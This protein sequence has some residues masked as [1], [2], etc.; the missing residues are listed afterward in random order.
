M[1]RANGANTNTEIRALFS[2]PL[3]QP[4][5][6]TFNAPFPAAGGGLGCSLASGQRRARGTGRGRAGEGRASRGSCAHPHT[7]LHAHGHGGGPTRPAPP[8]ES[9]RARTPA[10]PGRRVSDRPRQASRAK[11]S[12]AD[13]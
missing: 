2:H 13:K 1:V 12:G 10:N 4:K 5:K 6:A 11:T 9:R 3:R 7:K 8:G